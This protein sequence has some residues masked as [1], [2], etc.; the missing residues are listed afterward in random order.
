[1][2]ATRSSATIQLDID[3]V[4]AR[5]LDGYQAAVGDKTDER[6]WNVLGLMVSNSKCILK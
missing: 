1:M 4:Q 3:A 2:A 6:L 5:I